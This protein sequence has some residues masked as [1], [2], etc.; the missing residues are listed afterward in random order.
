ML[1]ICGHLQG[2][3]R[4]GA[5]DRNELWL[6]NK[7]IIA[8]DNTIENIHVGEADGASVIHI[9][10]GNLA[11]SERLQGWAEG[12]TEADIA[13]RHIESS[14]EDISRV[15]QAIL[16]HITQGEYCARPTPGPRSLFRACV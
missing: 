8:K 9:H 12:P 10:G 14:L 2:A 15:E 13:V 11:G 4:H 5:G 7:S 6:T 1:D 16:R 3:L